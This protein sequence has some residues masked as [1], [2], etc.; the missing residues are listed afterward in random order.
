MNA[1][2]VT[3]FVKGRF[4]MLMVL[5]VLLRVVLGV[6]LNFNYDIAFWSLIMENTL[7]GNGLYHVDGYFYAPIWGYFLGFTAGAQDLFLNVS[8]FGDIFPGASYIDGSGVSSKTFITNSAFNLMVKIPLFFLDV[9]AAYLIYWLIDDITG[10][11]K[12]AELA[13]IVWFLCPVVFLVSSVN[14]MFDVLMAVFVLL[15]VILVRRDRLFGAGF[16]LALAALLKLFPAFLAFPLLAYVLVKH[17]QSGDQLKSALMTVAGALA[18]LAAV[19]FPYVFTGQMSE[20]LAFLISRFAGGG[21]GGNLPA[22]VSY[23][24]AA[25]YI[26]ILLTVAYFSYRSMCGNAI[27]SDKGLIAMFALTACIVL[28]FPSNAQYYLMVF[29][30]V[31]IAFILGMERLR[32]SFVLMSA[33]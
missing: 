16:F 23:L 13:C 29:P 19:L 28:L 24:I 14:A 27:S 30:L 22:G 20:C 1:E 7:A 31:V 3:S 33:G 18:G 11:R 2:A 26:A 12:K 6:V 4:F 32:R 17:R 15:S 5:G 8:S 21:M 9:L 10:D 25:G